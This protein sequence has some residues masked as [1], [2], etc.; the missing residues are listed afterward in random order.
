M[1]VWIRQSHNNGQWDKSQTF[2]VIHTSNSLSFKV[3]CWMWFTP[4]LHQYQQLHK[5]QTHL[6]ALLFP[7]LRLKSEPEQST[8][9][10]SALNQQPG[11]KNKVHQNTHNRNGHKAFYS[12]TTS[13]P[14]RRNSRDG[15]KKK[16]L[17]VSWPAAGRSCATERASIAQGPLVPV[18][19]RGKRAAN[20][21]RS[22]Q[23]RFQ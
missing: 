14:R 9:L 5:S 17:K 12:S 19:Y 2:P 22:T 4:R 21:A 10:L 11:P 23:E 13:Q 7:S 3:A 16:F 1:R 8:A 6:H 18:A 15:T 20:T